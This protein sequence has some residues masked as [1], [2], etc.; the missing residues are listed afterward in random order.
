MKSQL[1]AWKSSRPRFKWKITL[2][3]AKIMLCAAY[4][5]EIELRGAAYSASRET[6]EI[7]SSIAHQMTD[8]KDRKWGILLCGLCGNGK[9]TMMRAI[10]SV[11][12]WLKEHNLL[13]IDRSVR[14]VDAKEIVIIASDKKESDNWT[15]LKQSLALGIDDLG[16]EALEIMEF[17]NV[18]EPVKELLEHR[19]DRQA[20]TVITTNLTPQQITERYGTRVG[21]RLSEMMNI[22]VF[23]E[24]SYRKRQQ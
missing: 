9:T 4:Q 16:C 11:S 22:I 7:I 19:Y 15:L 5:A 17:G 24:K 10:Q 18:K 23:S 3:Q 6:N 8:P 1:V 14:I 2:E 20:F 21:D 13:S 12:R